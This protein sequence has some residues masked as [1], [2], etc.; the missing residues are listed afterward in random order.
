MGQVGSNSSLCGENRLNLEGLKELPGGRPQRNLPFIYS[1]CESCLLN[2][3]R[4][5]TC[6]WQSASLFE[7]GN[8]TAP[9][10]AGRHRGGIEKRQRT[11]TCPIHFPCHLLV[12]LQPRLTDL[13][14]DTFGALI[15]LWRRKRWNFF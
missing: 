11:P 3:E 8:P 6:R 2:H 13:S 14:S 7:N 12:V 9:P 5:Y 10:L 1:S 15:P 4:D